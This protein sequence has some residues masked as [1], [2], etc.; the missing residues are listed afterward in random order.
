[1]AEKKSIIEEALL[2]V[3]KIKNALNA[4]TKEILRSV[5]KEEIAGLV[6]ESLTENDFEEETVDGDEDGEMDGEETEAPAGE[7]VGAETPD[8]GIEG[9]G[10]DETDDSAIQTSDEV[11]PEMGQEFGTDAD[12][13]DG[14]ELDMT[15]AS[16]DDVIAIYKKLSGEDEIEVVGDEIHMTIS[17]PGEYIVKAGGTPAAEAPVGDEAI[18]GEL[19]GDMGAEGGDDDEMSYE[20]AMDDDDD[21]D[22]E[23]PAEGGEEAPA[24]DDEEEPIAE[25]EA[26]VEGEEED[27]VKEAIPVGL[28]QAHRLPGKAK[29][30]QPKGAGAA[31]VKESTTTAKKIV[32]EGIE[33]KY[34]KL[35]TE[36]TK[37]KGQNEE[38][39]EALKK[40]RNMLVETVVFNSNLSYITRL[41]MEHATTKDE[42]K[43]FIQRFDEE[44]TTLEQSKR[45]YKTIVNELKSKKPV[46]EAVEN[47]IIKEVATGSSKQLNEAT[48]YVD[49][50][51]QRIKDLIK[52]VENKDKY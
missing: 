7:E 20:I 18:G 52:R 10:G 42:K 8:A 47:K 40:F 2:D 45:L 49:P 44:V 6:K 23:T 22:A 38:Y 1:M 29:I 14:D 41:F 46:N 43:K 31:S 16:D 34:N 26:P 33:V 32:T 4:N 51:T 39:K 35:L 50:S 11:E 48:A 25:G 15:D 12:A 37:L 24:T 30:G 19:G 5:A 21:D 27:L 28:A 3:T 36:A 9:I 13:L 17:E